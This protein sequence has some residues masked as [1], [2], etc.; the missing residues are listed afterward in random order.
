MEYASKCPDLRIS[1]RTI[2][3][4]DRFLKS[5]YSTRQVSKQVSNRFH[6]RGTM[7]KC[8]KDRKV[9]K[10]LLKKRKMCKLKRMCKFAEKLSRRN[11]SI[12]KLKIKN[13]D[14]TDSIKLICLSPKTKDLER[15]FFFKITNFVIIF[16]LQSN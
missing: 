12:A 3:K 11:I 1:N 16:F 5:Y 13:G 4:R 2:N 14:Q 10:K 9:R 15:F 8:K 7:R 6:D